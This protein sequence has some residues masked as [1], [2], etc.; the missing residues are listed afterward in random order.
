MLRAFPA[1][2]TCFPSCLSGNGGEEIHIERE[3]NSRNFLKHATEVRS[4]TVIHTICIKF[5]SDI[6]IL[7][8]GHT[9]TDTQT[10]RERRSHKPIFIFLNK[11]SGLKEL[12]KSCI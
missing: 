3:T 8:K 12:E 1:A 11:E 6:Q 5:G 9:S 2:G 10:Q 4:R 7:M